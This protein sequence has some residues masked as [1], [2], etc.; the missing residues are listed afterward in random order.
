MRYPLILKVIF[1]IRIFDFLINQK[2]SYYLNMELLIN[3]V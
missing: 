3:E 2:Y 1:R